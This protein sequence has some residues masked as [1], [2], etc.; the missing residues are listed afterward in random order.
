MQYAMKDKIR[1]EEIE[2]G[3]LLLLLLRENKTWDEL[4]Q[5]YV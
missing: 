5:R 4:C 2:N 3:A 1:Y